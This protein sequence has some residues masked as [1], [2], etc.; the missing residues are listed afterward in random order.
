MAKRC[1]QL[2][3]ALSSPRCL[4]LCWRKS[5]HEGFSGILTEGSTEMA[6]KEEWVIHLDISWAPAQCRALHSEMGLESSMKHTCP[7]GAESHKRSSSAKFSNRGLLTVSWELRLEPSLCIGDS[8]R[9]VEFHGK[10]PA[11][12]Y[13]MMPWSIL[14]VLPFHYLFAYIQFST[15]LFLVIINAINIITLPPVRHP[16]CARHCA[17]CFVILT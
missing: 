6:K 3:H 15:F 1:A 10:V 2:R 11:V 7:H 9:D 14:V 12:T 4:E 8:R 13:G 17:V 16:L 5:N